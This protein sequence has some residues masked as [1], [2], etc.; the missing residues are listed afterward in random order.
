M[1]ALNIGG[2][3]ARVVERGDGKVIDPRDAPHGTVVGFASDNSYLVR[4]DGY[5]RKEMTVPSVSLTPVKRTFQEHMRGTYADAWLCN[6]GLLI[7]VKKMTDRHLLNTTAFLRRWADAAIMI[8]TLSIL[9]WTSGPFAPRGEMACEALD[10][11]LH[12]L[13]RTSANEYL[14]QGCPPWEEMTREIQRRFPKAIEDEVEDF[15]G[16]VWGNS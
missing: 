1:V 11:E 16:D 3:V 13:G 14:R 9:S 2:R 6:N 12:A 4:W 10:S 15:F 5:K 8:E 7:L